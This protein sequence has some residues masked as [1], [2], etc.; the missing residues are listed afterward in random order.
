MIS[1]ST[2]ILVVDDFSL[3][4][5]MLSEALKGLGY[6]D[7]TEA[8]NGQ[9]AMVILEQARSTANPFS[10]LFLDW[11]MPVMTGLEVLTTCRST[12]KFSRIP[13]IMVTAEEEKANVM[14]ALVAGATGYIKKPITKDVLAKRI[15]EINSKLLEKGA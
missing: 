8:K 3:A 14:K 9:D 1:S 11:A 15:S 13:I 7:I 6:K 5:I 10:L 4:R 12:E 2:K